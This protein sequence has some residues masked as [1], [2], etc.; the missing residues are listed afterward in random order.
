MRGITAY[1]KGIR[2][3]GHRYFT[4]QQV[5]TALNL[6]ANAALVAIHR[7]RTQGEL[8]SP[9]RGLY[10]IVPPE[11]QIQG[12]IP[13]AELVPILMKYIHADYYVS[14]LSGAQ[15]YGV[16]HQKPARFQ[17]I[18]D[19]RIKHPLAFSQVRIEPIYKKSLQALPTKDF[20]V[21][22]GYL[23]V[24]T[25]E[26]ITLDLLKYPTRSGGLNHIATILSELIE[27]MNSDK[28]IALAEMVS[29]KAWLQRLGYIIEQVATADSERYSYLINKLATY[30]SGKVK[31]FIPLAPE[32]SE[33]S[34]SRI[35]RW[36]IIA[37]TAIESD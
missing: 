7:L 18:T 13:P 27:V 5:T 21:D 36:M 26:L 4:L 25:P 11:Y 16:A 23:K 29:E 3:Q 35:K 14:L 22:T 37:N 34:A 10:V 32:L 17:L 33:K 31:A 6:S 24:G 19:K 12:S 9:A 30:L 15:Y 2:R 1:I 28:L 20:V 8:I